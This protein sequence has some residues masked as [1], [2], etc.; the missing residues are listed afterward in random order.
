M[1][2]S[3]MASK[4][5][6]NMAVAICTRPVRENLQHARELGLEILLD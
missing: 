5:S 1:T 3:M 6:S 4:R 2:P